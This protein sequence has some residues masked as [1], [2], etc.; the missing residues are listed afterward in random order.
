MSLFT[1][2]ASFLPISLPV[3]NPEPP[4]LHGHLHLHGEHTH[5]FIAG[6]RSLLLV[7]PQ[8]L[9]QVLPPELQRDSVIPPRLLPLL[10]TSPLGPQIR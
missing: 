3:Y 6:P 1:H 8:V 5:S 9:P 7:D 2:L 10:C 4:A